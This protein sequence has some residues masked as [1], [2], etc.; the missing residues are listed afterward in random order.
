MR[1]LESRNIKATGGIRDVRNGDGARSFAESQE[2]TGEDGCK[3]PEAFRE[4]PIGARRVKTI[5][6][7][8]CVHHSS[9]WNS[10]WRTRWPPSI[11]PTGAGWYS[12]I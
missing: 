2:S 6:T 4:A 12:A 8:V 5:R 1:A 11:D 7:C 10:E 9:S 3:V